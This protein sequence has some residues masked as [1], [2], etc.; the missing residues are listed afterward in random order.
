MVL[1]HPIRVVVLLWLAAG[2]LP[3]GQAR[4]E[5]RTAFAWADRATADSYAPSAHYAKSDDAGVR[6]IRTESGV[7][8]VALGSLLAGAGHV[9][10][11]AYGATANGCHIGSWGSAGASVRC[12]DPAGRPA[13]TLFTILAIAAERDDGVAY[14]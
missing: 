2:A 8:R 13:D 5:I 3:A 9:Q 4:A 11:S 1:W 7:Y 12:F 14:V 10:V 6:V